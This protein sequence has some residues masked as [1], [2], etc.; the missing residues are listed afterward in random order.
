MWNGPNPAHW[1]KKKKPMMR[2]KTTRTPKRGGVPNLD[3]WVRMRY[4]NY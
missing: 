4:L 3:G 1:E 2:E